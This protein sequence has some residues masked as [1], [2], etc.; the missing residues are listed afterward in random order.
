MKLLRV[1]SGRL[2]FPSGIG[3]SSITSQNWQEL[4]KDIQKSLFMNYILITLCIYPNTTPNLSFTG[5]PQTIHICSNEPGW[6]Q[7]SFFPDDSAHSNKVKS[8]SCAFKRKLFSQLKY[9]LLSNV[10]NEVS[11]LTNL[12]YGIT[13]TT[14][15]FLAVQGIGRA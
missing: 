6:A 11:R 14:K 4:S 13:H 1:F 15:H 3:N 10:K 2:S 12:S 5:F 7:T 8:T 9:Q